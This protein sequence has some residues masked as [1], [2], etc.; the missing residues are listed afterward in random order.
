MATADLSAEDRA[1]FSSMAD[2]LIPQYRKMPAASVVG[3]Q[4]ALLDSVLNHRPDIVEDFL[5]AIRSAK[6][7]P[8]REAVE[9]LFAK[10]VP[11]FDAFSLATSAAYYMSPLV[12]ERL[13]YPG[14]E[15]APFDAHETPEY[16][17]NG[18]L[19]RVRQRGAIYRPTPR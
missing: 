14:Q 13:G 19:D 9:A 11:A 18:L 8:P 5:R 17:T 15:N 2:V 3:V 1:I 4:D 16:E 6:S 12:W 7:T 10:D